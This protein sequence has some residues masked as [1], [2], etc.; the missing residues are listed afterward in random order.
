MTF[1]G[2]N[3]Q[4]EQSTDLPG[5]CPEHH[6]ERHR[7]EK[8]TKGQH[9]KLGPESWFG[10]LRKRRQGYE[11]GKVVKNALGRTGRCTRTEHHR[12]LWMTAR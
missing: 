1:C 6:V 7:S 9:V 3:G 8:V 5:L 4:K 2:E 10:K 12:I 11:S